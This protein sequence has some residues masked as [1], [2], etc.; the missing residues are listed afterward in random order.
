MNNILNKKTGIYSKLSTS[1]YYD[2]KLYSKDDP[3]LTYMFGDNEYRD[4]LISEFYFNDSYNINSIEPKLYS[5]CKPW[6]KAI[7]NGVSLDNIGF[8]GMDNGLI[9]F[10]DNC[11]EIKNNAENYSYKI[12]ECTKKQ[13]LINVKGYSNNYDYKIDLEKDH[14]KL[15]GG[16]FQGFFKIKNK[17]YQVIPTK[18]QKEWGF[19]FVLTKQDYECEKNI[20]DT[21]KDN[22]GTFFYLGTRAENKF[23]YFSDNE[24]CQYFNS[25]DSFVVPCFYEIENIISNEDVDFYKINSIRTETDNKY[26]THNRTSNGLVAGGDDDKTFVFCDTKTN[27]NYN[28]FLEYNR[29][30]NNTIGQIDQSII[31]SNK[32]DLEKDIINNCISFIIKDDGSI[33]YRTLTQKPP[34][35]RIKPCSEEYY[36]NLDLDNIIGCD[37]DINTNIII[38]KNEGFSKP[39]II[40]NGEKTHVFVRYITSDNIETEAPSQRMCVLM[41]YVNGKLVFKSDEFLEPNFRGLDEIKEKQEGVPF[42]MSIGG[43]TLGLLESVLFNNCI[44]RKIL[45]IEENFCGSFIGD[46]YKFKMFNGTVDYSK[47]FNNYKYELKNIN[48]E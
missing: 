35:K 18:P 2:L 25:N 27:K 14:I 21:H 20:N 23:W 47:I 40:N 34:T 19:E 42:N 10:G 33:G 26:L 16:F 11:D 44:D 17:D 1:E 7:N 24:D 37:D 28:G 29:S 45:P 30:N 36:D 15:K 31:Y 13:F 22:K 46:I 12:D 39:N 32:I 43:G 5:S 8:V 9:P 38:I 48:N 41:F 6:Y 4:D 3:D